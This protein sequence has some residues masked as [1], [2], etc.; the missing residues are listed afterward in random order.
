MVISPGDIVYSIAGRDKGCYFAVMA[1]DD[2]FALICDGRNR[3]TDKPKRKKVK[4]I[5]TGYGHSDCIAE[6]IEKG[7]RVTNADL[8]NELKPYVKP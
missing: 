6:K 3:K 7:E 4:H 8:K 5:K 2:N 1:V